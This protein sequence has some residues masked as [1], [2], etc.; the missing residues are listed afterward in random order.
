MKIQTFI[1]A[2]ALFGF[3]F[4]T[5]AASPNCPK[6]EKGAAAGKEHA[7]GKP[8]AK[9]AEMRKKMLE[10][11]DADKDGKLSEEER[12]A[13]QAGRRAE[14]TKKFDA[15]GDGELSQEEKATMK[16]E[17]LKRLDKDG[18]GEVSEEERKAAHHGRR[19]PGKGKGK[20][21]GGEAAK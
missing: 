20:K 7:K 3:V 9:G 6:K 21:K 17:M 10:K 5:Q 1:F 19:G 16:A 2:L 11:Y 15:D 8:G 12:K 13:A 4:G 14:M 18:D